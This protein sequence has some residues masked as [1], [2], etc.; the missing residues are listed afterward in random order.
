ME[1]PVADDQFESA[2]A[3]GPTDTGA[4][5][6]GYSRRSTARRPPIVAGVPVRTIATT[7]MMVLATVATLWLASKVTRIITWL[8]VS[9]FF[10]VVLTPVVD[11]LHRKLRLP[12]AFATTVVFIGCIVVLVGMLY[13]F[14][15][16]IVDQTTKFSDEFPTYVEKAQN[17]EGPVGKLVKKYKVEEWVKDN[18]EKW[19][20]S[21]DN[22]G[23]NALS[24]VQSVFNTLAATL[25]MAVLTFLMLLQGPELL[26]GMVRVL[27]P[28]QQ[29]RMRRIGRSS[30]KAIT[31]YVAGNLAISVIAGVATWIMLLVAGVPFAGVLALWVAYADLIPLVGA[32]L[33]AIPAVGVA[34][35]HSVPAGIAVLIFYVVY[36]Q[37]EN[38]V[39]Q[40]NIMSR[41]VSLRP[42]IVLIT[43]LMGVELYG[44]LGALLAIPA[45]GVIKVVG[46]EILYWRRP[47]LIVVEHAHAQ[48]HRRP[49][50]TRWARWPWTNG[51]ATGP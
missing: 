12:R 45:A 42:L 41:T 47:E 46:T 35:L 7:I 30:S 38:H 51:S 49:R 37:V 8:V 13:A 14:I 16:P 4:V 39:L 17:G 9:I 15:R 10:T 36:Q 2:D 24:I 5:P 32:T 20:S 19:R 29:E 31:G 48:P 43:V 28:P 27:S 3:G 23:R 40:P 18:Q 1:H 33:G 6:D 26:H 44:L 21:V 22:I 34:F 25:T 50:W 11:R